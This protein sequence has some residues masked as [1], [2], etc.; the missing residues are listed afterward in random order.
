MAQ[1]PSNK[2]IRKAFREI[3]EPAIKGM[4]FTGK[5]PEFRRSAKSETHFILIFTRKYGGGFS[6][7]G[8][9]A[10]RG[11]F[12]HWDDQIIPEDKLEFAHTDFDN[13][14]HIERVLTLC[15]VDGRMVRQSAGD[16][17]YE[18]ILADEDACRTLVKEAANALPQ[19]DLWLQTRK[20][21]VNISCRGHRLR[22]GV[23]SRLRWHMITGRYGNFDLS[24]RPPETPQLDRKKE[25]DICDYEI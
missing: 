19:L 25:K 12:L 16:F 17:D 3:V 22:S 10:P 1:R 9:W 6:I 15:S 21:N 2:F 14:A 18:Q 8:A 7:S 13:R 23:S 4:G 20:A 5:Y 11:N 24:N